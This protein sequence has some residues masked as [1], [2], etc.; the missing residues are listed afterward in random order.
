[1]SYR[2]N[3]KVKVCICVYK[4]PWYS[5][6]CFLGLYFWMTFLCIRISLGCFLQGEGG[7]ARQNTPFPHPSQKMRSQDDFSRYLLKQ[8][9]E[10]FFDPD[11]CIT[12]TCSGRAGFMLLHLHLSASR[13]EAPAR[14]LRCLL[15]QPPPAASG[16]Q[17][18]GR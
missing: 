1:M 9:A 18:V 3:E 11:G 6:G 10:A 17:T 7:V 15:A 14:C 13:G 2:A 4:I 5:P 12:W 16:R 8:Q